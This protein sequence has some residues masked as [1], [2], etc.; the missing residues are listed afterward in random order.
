MWLFN[1]L[2]L[3]PLSLLPVLEM[4]ATRVIAS[5]G[6]A[7]SGVLL[8]RGQ[9]TSKPQSLHLC[10]KNGRLLTQKRRLFT[11]NA[12]QNPQVQTKE[13]GQPETLD[14]RVFFLD[15]SGKKVCK[16]SVVS[17]S[18]VLVFII[19]VWWWCFRFYIGNL[20]S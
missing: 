15:N 17:R 6:S 14:Y 18:F 3:S 9:L 5:A 12:I 4:A 20:R 10:F 13:E 8:S 11:C 7:I 19:V 1:S 16:N 2:S